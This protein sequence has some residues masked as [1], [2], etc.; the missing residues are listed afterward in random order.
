MEAPRPAFDA[1]VVA[2]RLPTARPGF[3]A[4]L[5]GRSSTGQSGGESESIPASEATPDWTAELLRTPQRAAVE[6]ADS[7]DGMALLTD[8]N[9]LPLPLPAPPAGAVPAAAPTAEAPP[10]HEL[11]ASGAT[12]A[13][14]ATKMD[15]HATDLPEAAG[16]HAP[17]PET[18]LADDEI[19]AGAGGA[20]DA[21][22]DCAE[23]DGAVTDQTELELDGP[24]DDPD[25]ATDMAAELKTAEE[26][27]EQVKIVLTSVLDRLGSA[28]H[29]PFSRS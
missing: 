25:G 26:A 17:T 13:F 5:F 1:S 22:A 8:G 16:A 9:P 6:P 11:P 19:A 21:A 28:H 20:R 10:Q 14:G 27:A 18:P 24:A 3:F 29:R 23:S 4:R 12:D 2:T 15:A 7:P